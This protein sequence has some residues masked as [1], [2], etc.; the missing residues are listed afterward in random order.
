MTNPGI[1][2]LKVPWGLLFV[3]NATALLTAF[4]GSSV[5][6]AV[7]DIG[8]QFGH[9]SLAVGWV[10]S[11]FIIASVAVLVP[12]G[13]L[14]DRGSVWRRNI[15]LF[16]LLL[17]TLASLASPWSL[18][19]G[20]LIFFR[21]LQGI[22]SGA[23]YATQLAILTESVP[24]AIRGRAIGMN[25]SAVY[26]GLSVGPVLGGMLTHV[27]G[28]QGVFYFAAGVGVL[29]NLAAFVLLKSATEKL[30]DTAK[31]LRLLDSLLFAS[32]IS[33]AMVGISSLATY[34]FAWLL[35]ASGAMLLVVFVLLELRREHP[36]MNLRLFADP[37]YAFSNLAALISYAATF[38]V[39]FLLSVY[40]QD[41]RGL[42]AAAA[43]SILLAQPVMMA[44]VA[45]FAGRFSEKVQPRL[46]ASWGIGL[47]AAALF[48]LV[49]LSATIS[50]IFVVLAL[51]VLGIGFGLF[52][53][54]N[55]NAVM[56][57]VSFNFYGIA[58]STL[59]T[60]RVLGNTL[61]MSLVMFL[62]GMMGATVSGAPVL[63][64]MLFIRVSFVVFAVLCFGGVFLS[65]RRGHIK[66]N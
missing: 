36:L 46:L 65:L 55:A 2:P 62:A 25:V 66:L 59:A 16:G 35:I 15:F 64:V 26:I 14:S 31:P 40:L 57:C 19:L 3:L 41:V 61:S 37:G 58:G 54:P 48:A 43:G 33:L 23:I 6:L 22:A 52:S 39:G 8:R 34:F 12:L 51:I 17:F 9:P 42:T 11:S 24:P 45:P 47:V 56:S 63:T 53:S 21:T 50:L 18:S 1:K 13:A 10:V 4:V 29:V 5:N 49:W 44:L 38:A 28:W 30:L 32:G 27:F 7:P 60:M 20:A